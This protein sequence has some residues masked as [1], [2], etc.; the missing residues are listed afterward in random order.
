LLDFTH[1]PVDGFQFIR[2]PTTKE[3]LTMTKKTAQ[4]QRIALL[5]AGVSASMASVAWGQPVKPTILSATFNPPANQITIVGKNFTPAA[6]APSV[7][8][9]SSL[10][11]VASWSDSI[12]VAGTPP[13]MP[14]ASY[15]LSVNNGLIGSFVAALDPRFGTNTSLAAAGTGATCTLGQVMLT[16]GVVANGIPATGQL[17]PINGNLPLFTLLGDNYGGDGLTT[18]AIPDLRGVAPNGLTYTICTLGVFPS[19]N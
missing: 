6:G 5:A 15:G 16:A 8:L 10:L 3:N 7:K 19:Q 9:G 1:Y 12:I 18:F 17:L 2:A 4:L 14:A 11:T 13:G